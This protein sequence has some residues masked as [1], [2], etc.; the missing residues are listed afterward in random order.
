MMTISEQI[1]NYEQEIEKALAHWQH[2]AK[3]GCSDP[4]WPDGVNMNLVRNHIIWYL[5]HIAELQQKPRQIS[6]FETVEKTITNDVMSDPRLP[7]QVDHNYMATDR[8]LNVSPEENARLVRYHMIQDGAK[9][10]V[11]GH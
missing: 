10:E 2:M 5:V 8:K 1:A 6:M 7:I 4:F 11:Q 3:Y 9:N